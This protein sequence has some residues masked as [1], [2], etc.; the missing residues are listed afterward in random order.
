[1]RAALIAYYEERLTPGHRTWR[2][3]AYGPTLDKLRSGQPVVLQGWKLHAVFRPDGP[4]QPYATYRV[5]SDGRVV[6]VQPVREPRDSASVVGY[7]EV[8]R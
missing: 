8:T 6:Q 4:P 1:M 5:E 3:L 7:T 2:D